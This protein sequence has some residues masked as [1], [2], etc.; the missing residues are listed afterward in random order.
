MHGQ[1]QLGTRVD[2]GEE[3]VVRLS[4]GL[5]HHVVEVADRLVVVDAEAES[6]PVDHCYSRSRSRWTTVGTKPSSSTKGRSSSTTPTDRCRP[7]V[8]PI[9]TVRYALPSRW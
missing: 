8:H 9:A 5:G 6:Q 7:P 3:R 4:D 2:A 1:A